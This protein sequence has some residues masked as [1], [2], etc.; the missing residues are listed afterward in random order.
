MRVTAAA[1]ALRIDGGRCG[2]DE[3]EEEEEDVRPARHRWYIADCVLKCGKLAEIVGTKTTVYIL[4]FGPI[5]CLM[6]N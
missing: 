1:A 6:A 5:Q 2:G 4:K 3:E